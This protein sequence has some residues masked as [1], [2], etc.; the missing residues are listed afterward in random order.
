MACALVAVTSCESMLEIPQKGVVDYSKFYASDDDALA[1]ITSMYATYL[2]NVAGT[3]GI[4]NPEQVMLNYSAD[5]IMPAGGYDKD[6]LDFRVFGEFAYDNANPTLKSAYERYV[7]VIYHANLV[8]S[9]FTDENK[10][11]A[12]PKH[13]SA[14]VDQVVAEARVMR[15]YI[16]MM[17]ALSWERPPIVDRLQEGDDLP[18]PAESQAQVLRWVVEQCQIAIDS[19]ALP[20]RKVKTQRII[21]QTSTSL[22]TVT[23]RRSLSQTL[24]RILTISSVVDGAAQQAVVSGVVA[25]WLRT[26]S[27]GV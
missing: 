5:D 21:G 10:Q 22:V 15:A 27:T 25:G 7:K 2:D 11:G 20:V 23:G 8:I 12:A 18:V 26:C 24:S 14:Y 16:H 17:M 4:D 3:E 9:N 1:A 19:K 13:T 6:H